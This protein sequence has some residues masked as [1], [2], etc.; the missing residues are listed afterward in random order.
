MVFFEDALN[1]VLSQNFTPGNER[2]ALS[3]S[4]GRILAEDI[5]SDMDM[6]PFDKSAVDGFA[7]RMADVGTHHGMS[8]PDSLQI[9]ETIP[10]GT[11]PQKIILP[12]QCAKI[13]TG[14]MVPSGADCVVMVEFS[15]MVGENQVRLTIE[16]PA[17]NI[18]YRAED[19][20]SGEHVL[21]KGIQINPAHVAVLASVGAINPLVGRL[22]T[23]GIIST[24]DELV[25]PGATP[26]MAQIR[27]S[28]AWQLE[29]QVKTVPALSTYLGIAPDEGP[30][31]RLIIDL[32]LANN[33][34]VLLTGGVSMGDFDFVP[35]IMQEAGIEILFKSV[36][37]Q[38]GKPTV[39]GRRNNTYIFGLP[40]NPVSSFVLFEMMVK[41]FLRL[42]MGCSSEPLVLKLPMGVDFSRRKSGRMSMIPVSI[43]DN[44]VFPVEYHG[45]A[46]I[47]AYTMANG[48]MF[49]DIGVT[50]INKGDQVYVRPI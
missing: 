29:A 25:E 9:I 12:G 22:P 23:V 24:G 2:I 8:V 34:V 49:M 1:T 16:T 26:G 38:P 21:Q 15:E 4:L 41:P 42:M 28:N 40:G 50:T 17:K 48:I 3:E 14:A 32:A 43:K 33:D 27:N 13:M 39:F 11:I 45:S 5:F 37:I 47:N 7:C 46:H 36:A 31:L 44:S 10:A 6:P 19:I 20:K 18:C 30:E 35:V